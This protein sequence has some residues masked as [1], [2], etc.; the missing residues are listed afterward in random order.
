MVVEGRFYFV[1]VDIEIVVDDYVFFVIDDVEKIVFIDV[2][3]IFGFLEVVL[4][5]GSGLFWIVE[6][7]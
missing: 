4:K 6:V 1:G 7:V 2:V 5:F 3:Y